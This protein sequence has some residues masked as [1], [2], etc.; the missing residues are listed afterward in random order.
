VAAAS[1][2]LASLEGE[3]KAKR[4][5]LATIEAALKRPGGASEAT[6]ARREQLAKEITA[7][8]AEGGDRK[9]LVEEHRRLQTQKPELEAAAAAAQRRYAALSAQ[10][11]NGTEFPQRLLD[12][13]E[14]IR[15]IDPPVDPETP[16]TSRLLYVLFGVAASIVLG[17]G[18]AWA[19][20]Q[21]DPSLRDRQQFAAVAGVP[22]V[23]HLPR[24]AAPGDDPAKE[25][26]SP[27]RRLWVILLLIGL[28]LLSGLLL[29]NF[30][31]LDSWWGAVAGLG[32]SIDDLTNPQSSFPE[33]VLSLFRR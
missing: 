32:S 20:E 8:E 28:V 1:G 31:P 11:E 18:L 2:R 7:L 33:S 30:A 17:V 13:P 19:A 24:F 27:E 25:R 15:I 29:F 3:I 6:E 10:Y 5:D 14:R 12:A 16:E 22:V 21:A 23:A 26:R 9:A 4:S